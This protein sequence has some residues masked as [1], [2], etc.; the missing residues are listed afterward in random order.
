MFAINISNAF[1]MFFFFIPAVSQ[2]ASVRQPIRAELAWRA[3]RGEEG[4]LLEATRVAVLV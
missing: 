2:L 3:G 4:G 1:G